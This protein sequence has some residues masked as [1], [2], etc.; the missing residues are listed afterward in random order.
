MVRPDD[1]S[2]GCYDQVGIRFSCDP[3][4]LLWEIRTPE[5]IFGFSIHCAKICET[6]R[7]TSHEV[8]NE[9]LFLAEKNEREKIWQK[10][11]RDEKR[12]RQREAR[13]PV[14]ALDLF[15]IIVGS[16]GLIEDI[17]QRRINDDLNL[18]DQV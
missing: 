13:D 5:N 16:Y 14:S 11:E 3:A 12:E 10:K 7:A 1:L 4:R 9:C 2:I 8:Y 17:E 6:I 18:L 15:P